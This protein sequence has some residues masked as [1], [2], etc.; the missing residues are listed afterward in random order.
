MRDLLRRT[1]HQYAWKGPG[2]EMPPPFRLIGLP[3]L[4]GAP[5]GLPGV[6]AGR[7]LR[8]DCRRHPGGAGG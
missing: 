6:P 4:P 5:C 1:G 2:A 8:R 7:D 3:D